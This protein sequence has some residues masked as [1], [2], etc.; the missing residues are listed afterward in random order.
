MF[1]ARTSIQRALL[2]LLCAFVFIAQL[3]AASHGVWH[4]AR[5][6]PAEDRAAVTA[7]PAQ[8]PLAPELAKLC[9][10]DLAFG[11]VL[12]GGP[13]SSF[14]F[15][16]HAAVDDAAPDVELRLIAAHPPVPHSRGPPAL[17]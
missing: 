3:G 5:A 14:A 13:V 2:P 9:I 17:L 11:Q 15:T 7:E 12:G 16:L 10:F 1:E 4:A 8:A 6:L